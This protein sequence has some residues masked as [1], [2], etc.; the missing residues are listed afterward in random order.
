MSTGEHPRAE[1]GTAEVDGPPRLD[2]ELSRVHNPPV[3]GPHYRNLL[4]AIA[5]LVVVI[6]ATLLLAPWNSAPRQEARQAPGS[7]DRTFLDLPLR[8]AAEPE[9]PAAPWWAQAPEPASETEGWYEPPPA[10]EPEPD[11]DPRQL[12]LE[13]ALR[14]ASLE[15]AQ[16]RQEAD[17]TAAESSIQPP[18]YLTSGYASLLPSLVD[19]PPDAGQRRAPQAEVSTPGAGLSDVF[20]RTPSGVRAPGLFANPTLKPQPAPRTLAA[21]TLIPVRL[22]TAINSDAP[23]PVLARVLRDVLDTATGSQVLIPAG[24]QL[25]G[26]VS[27]QLAYGDGRVL[28]AFDQLSFPG[29][30]YRLPG[31]ESLE[32]SG[33][34]GLSGRVDR[35]VLPSIGRAALLA[36]VGAGFQLSQPER[37]ERTGLSAGE[38]ISAQLGLELGRVS[39]EL[40]S[41]GLRRRPTV[42]IRAGERFYVFLPTDLTL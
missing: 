32:T 27:N 25:L 35:H 23:G 30:S 22:E 14:S 33:A 13:R 42:R 4:L 1:P 7:P 34:R 24:A 40:L 10:A 21:G 29:A 38:V 41:Q 8:E 37:T 19:S 3:T 31:L 18:R 11:P 9:T 26:S 17:N 5:L 6:G 16:T 39:Q 20:P 2:S 15:Q 12:A 28:V 36:A